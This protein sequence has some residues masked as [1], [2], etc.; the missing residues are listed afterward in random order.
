MDLSTT[1]RFD[2]LSRAGLDGWQTVYFFY[3]AGMAF[4]V[5]MAVE[6]IR[7][8]QAGSWLWII[9]LF[10]PIG[11]A[12]YFFSEYWR[13][14]SIGLRFRF[15]RATAAEE[16]TAAAESRRL[17]NGASWSNYASILRARGKFAL[18]VDAARKALERDP[19]DITA[20]YELGRGLLGAG[21][22]KE[23]VTAFQDVLAKDRWF[24]TGDALLALAKAQDAAGDSAAA[25][26]TFEEL[27]EKTTR[28]EVLYHLATLQVA[29]GER[30][31]ASVSLQ[32]IIDE[33]D[34]VPAYHRRK[35][36]PWVRRARQA[37]KRL[38]AAKT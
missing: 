17:D 36:Q 18:A 21:L 6:A 1:V 19:T 8:G 16:Q 3:L 37:I 27:A 5:W 9:L 13:G 30:E 28:P 26:A 12:V 24:D 31:A 15:Q 32:R 20:R 4:T 38:A 34:Y 2:N 35:I 10:G 33:A 14:P 23:A 11:S 7:R 29:A 25:R 22:P